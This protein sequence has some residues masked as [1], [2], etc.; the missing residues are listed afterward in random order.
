MPNRTAEAQQTQWE[1]QGAAAAGPRFDV[2][3]SHK[4][5]QRLQGLRS[6]KNVEAEQQEAALQEEVCDHVH[7]CMRL[8]MCADMFNPAGVD[9][10]RSRG[11]HLMDMFTQASLFATAHQQLACQPTSMPFSANLTIFPIS[12]KASLCLMPL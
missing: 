8:A 12:A 5:E 3:V 7:C 1:A 10:A 11:P 2:A 9:R 6:L 4:V